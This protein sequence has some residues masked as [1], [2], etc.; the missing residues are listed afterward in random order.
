MFQLSTALELIIL[1]SPCSMTPF[2]HKYN[3]HCLSSGVLDIGKCIAVGTNFQHGHK[4]KH[5]LSAQASIDPYNI[6]PN[7]TILQLHFHNY[8]YLHKN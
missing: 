7:G 2:K 4:A 3:I 5:T 8:K 1:L 6:V